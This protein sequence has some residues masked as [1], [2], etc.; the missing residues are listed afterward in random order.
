MT[1]LQRLQPGKD[2]EKKLT[3]VHHSLYA[4]SINYFQMSPGLPLH[5]NGKIEMPW[6]KC[7]GEIKANKRQYLSSSGFGLNNGITDTTKARQDA[8]GKP[9]QE[10]SSMTQQG[11]LQRK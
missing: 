1:P 10:T 6:K 3:L 8:R 4:E 7:T 9:G 11:K 5:W 2:C